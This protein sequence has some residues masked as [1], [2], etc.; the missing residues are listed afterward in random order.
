MGMMSDAVSNS[1]KCQKLT[2]STTDQC[3]CWAN[4]TVLMNRI[5]QFDC[6]A[7]KTQK[8]VTAHQNAC[9]AVFSN[10]KKKEDASVSH[11]AYCMNDH[12]MA[13]INQS[14][15]TLGTGNLVTFSNI[16]PNYLF[17]VF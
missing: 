12:S 10:C 17:N 5:K 16:E 7:K 11:V 3:N 14:T 15:D 4:Q 6:L 8:L 2:N 9:I 13:F 1:K